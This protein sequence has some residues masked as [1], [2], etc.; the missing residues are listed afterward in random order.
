MFPLTLISK[1]YYIHAEWQRHLRLGGVQS[2]STLLPRIVPLS[3]HC[4]TYRSSARSLHSE[5]RFRRDST[6]ATAYRTPRRLPFLV[7]YHPSHRALEKDSRT[8]I[9]SSIT[10]FVA[11][12]PIWIARC[13][14]GPTGFS[15]AH[16]APA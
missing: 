10:F 11:E 13:D 15:V 5:H 7:I 14:Q 6:L 9:T 3:T 8:S 4:A 2:N 16:I 1:P 12:A